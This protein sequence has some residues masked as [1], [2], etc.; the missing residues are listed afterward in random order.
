MDRR[1]VLSFLAVAALCV[2]GVS[3]LRGEGPGGDTLPIRVRISS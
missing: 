3:A 2:G 1:L